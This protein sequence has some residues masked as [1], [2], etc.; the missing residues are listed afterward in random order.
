MAFFLNLL[1]TAEMAEQLEYIPALKNALGAWAAWFGK[2]GIEQLKGDLR[3]YHAT[4]AS[5]YSIFLKKGIINEDPY[6]QEAKVNDIHTPDAGPLIE[7]NHAN[8]I[9]MRLASFDN[10]LEFLVNFC[11]LNPD[12]L[13]LERVKRIRSLIAYVNWG[14]LAVNSES[15]ITA[16]VAGMVEQSKNGADSLLQGIISESVFYIGRCYTSILSRLDAIAAYRKEIFKLELRETVTS[17]MTPEEAGQIALVK[18][19]F[20]HVH[21]KTPLPV[22]LAEE[23]IREDR[24][25]DGPALRQAILKRFSPHDA[26]PAEEAKA[27]TPFKNLLLEAVQILGGCSQTLADIAAKIDVNHSVLVS[28]K[29]GFLETLKRLLTQMFN[30]NA[31]AEIYRMEY[32]DPLKGSRVTEQIN[33]AEFRASMAKKFRALSAFNT[34]GQTMARSENKDEKAIVDSLEHYV[35]EL[36]GLYRTLTGLDEYFKVTVSRKDR[37]RIKGIRPEL[38]ALKNT[39]LRTNA[40]RH[41]YDAWKEETEGKIP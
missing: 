31:A 29:K 2:T 10:Q 40:K 14:N 12:Y 11:P 37:D 9:S 22:E 21:P 27:Q 20:S 23:V 13:T 39:I 30:S 28:E 6:K 26:K 3:G 33:Y 15:P 4:F 36:Q 5:L 38:A 16:A 7:G 1:H 24:P 32:L 18:K 17:L 25:K 19:R 8:D 34:R 41:E 35:R